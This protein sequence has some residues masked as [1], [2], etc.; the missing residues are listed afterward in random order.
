MTSVI[1]SEKGYAAPE[2]YDSAPFVSE[3][4]SDGYSPAARTLH[5]QAAN[6]IPRQ[7]TLSPFPLPVVK[8]L[9][10]LAAPLS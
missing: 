4:Q 6:V 3:R 9:L 1:T 2:D 7:L 10:F 5:R 8:R